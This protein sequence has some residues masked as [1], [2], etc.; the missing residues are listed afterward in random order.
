LATLLVVATATLTEAQTQSGQNQYPQND[1]QSRTI[2]TNF[3]QAVKIT[4]NT[5][6]GDV[7]AR[8]RKVTRARGGRVSTE[9]DYDF[10]ITVELAAGKREFTLQPRE[11][12]CSV[13]LDDLRDENVTEGNV[14]A[15]A[16]PTR[17][18]PIARFFEALFPTLSAQSYTLRQVYHHIYTCGIACAGGVDGL[19]AQQ[20]WL[21]YRYNGVNA[22]MD[23]GTGGWSCVAGS[24]YGLPNVGVSN[25]Q[26]P[27]QVPGVPMF[28]VNTGWWTYNF[29]ATCRNW[30]PGPSVS[31]CNQA[32][33]FW[34]LPG[35]T[36]PR[37]WEHTLYITQ[38]AYSNGNGACT[39]YVTG[40]YVNGPWQGACQINAR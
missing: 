18:N 23:S 34:V 24:T 28:P 6:R 27:L 21:N 38:T 30:G 40:S 8:G 3:P 25:C 13:V 10:G 31:Q 2:R 33:Y 11:S 14:Q 4:R 20:G 15:K 26:P 35:N 32:S 5:G 1:Q 16:S 9:C 19:T 7:L 37:L 39:S 36:I 22:Q 12:D 17:P 29:W